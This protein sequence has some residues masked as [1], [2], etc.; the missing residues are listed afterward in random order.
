MALKF[1]IIENK[2]KILN[3]VSNFSEDFRLSHLNKTTI[4]FRI[5]DI[6]N[7]SEYSY[8]L[9]FYIATHKLLHFQIKSF[10]K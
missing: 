1:E 5:R 2:R 7:V 4:K 6:V 8:T 3:C 9:G 10:K